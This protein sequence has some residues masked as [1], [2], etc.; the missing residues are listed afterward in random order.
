[1]CVRESERQAT[2]LHDRELED[3]WREDVLKTLGFVKELSQLSIVDD[4]CGK[5]GLL[6]LIS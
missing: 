2:T 1:M 4:T 5:V 6:P 3:I